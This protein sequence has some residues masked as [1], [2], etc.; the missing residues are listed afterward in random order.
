MGIARHGLSGLKANENFASPMR[1]DFWAR[2]YGQNLWIYPNW[3]LDLSEHVQEI[4]N[5]GYS[6]LVKMEESYPKELRLSK[7]TSDFNWD[8]KLL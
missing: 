1:E 2:H 6:Y 4:E 5:A 8:N 3:L 7:R